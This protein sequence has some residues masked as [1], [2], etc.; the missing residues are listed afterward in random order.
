MTAAT[1][2]T[3][4]TVFA[5]MTT[6]PI[7]ASTVP[8]RWPEGHGEGGRSYLS[9]EPGDASCVRGLRLGNRAEPSSLA[10]VGRGPMLWIQ[11]VI[12]SGVPTKHTSFVVLN[13]EARSLQ[14]PLDGVSEED[15]RAMVAP[16]EWKW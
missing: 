9:H 2:A 15:A 3:M 8:R 4:A 14:I 16:G 7:L 6:W 11:K 10:R 5:A 12:E 13:A 1:T